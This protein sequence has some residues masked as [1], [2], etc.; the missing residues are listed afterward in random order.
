MKNKKLLLITI[1]LFMISTIVYASLL[2]NL[3]MS[4]E[5]TIRALADIRVTN[6]SYD[7][8]NSSG[9]TLSY[10]STFTKNTIISG[11]TLPNTSSNMS[12]IVTITNNGEM[13]QAIYNLTNES[14]NNGLYATITYT[15]ENN[16]TYTNVPINEALP[17][18][19]PLKSR[20]TIIVTYQTTTPGTINVVSTFD[21]RKVYYIDYVTRSTSTIERTIK[22]HNINTTITDQIPIKQGYPFA[23]WTDEQSGEVVKFNPGDLYTLNEDKTLYALYTKDAYV[24]TFDVDNGEENQT[25]EIKVGD[26]VGTLPTVTKD[27]YHFEGWFTSK[28]GG[29]QITISTVPT[30]DTTYYAHY[31]AYTMTIN[32]YAGGASKDGN[33]TLSNQKLTTD[34]YNYDGTDLSSNGLKN[35]DSASGTW[36]LVKEGY[37]ADKYWH[38]N[39]ATSNTKVH[40]DTKYNKIQDLAESIGKLNQFKTSNIEINIYA[41]WIANE[42]NIIFDKNSTYAT[43]IMS[44]QPMIYGQTDTLN[45]NLFEKEGCTFVGWNTKADGSGTAY[46][47][48]ES[49]SNLVTSGNITLYAQWINGNYT[50]TFD[51]NGGTGT[52]LNQTIEMSELTA[53]KSNEFTNTGYT[54]VGWN[55]KKDGSGISYLDEQEVLN[56]TSINETITLYAQWTANG[57]ALIGNTIYNSLQTA[58]DAVSTTSETPTTIILLK[59][60]SEYVEIESGQNIIFNFQNFILSNDGTKNILYNQGNITITN[61][62]LRSNTSQGAINNYGKL[63]MTGGKIETTNASTR[64]AIYNA[65][66]DVEIS[67]T[68]YLSSMSNSRATLQ[69]VRYNNKEG[70]ITIKSGTIISTNYSAIQLDAG[71]LIIGTDDSELSIDSPH[72]KG[73]NNGILSNTKEYYFYDG[74][75]EG[76]NSF[77]N[78]TKVKTNDNYSME[79]VQYTEGSVTYKKTYLTK[80]AVITLDPNEGTIDTPQILVKVGEMIGELPKPTRENYT[81]DGWYNEDEEEITELFIVEGDMILYAHWIRSEDYYVASIG[82]IQYHSIQAAINAVPANT[83]TTIKLIRNTKEVVNIPSNKNII[84]DGQNY[85]LSNL[86]NSAII[87]NNGKLKIINGTIISTSINAAVI[88]NLGELSITGGRISATGLRQAIYNDGGQLEI[89]GTAYLSSTTSERATIQNRKNETSNI[90]GTTLITGGTIVSTNFAAVFNDE[91]L[92]TIGIEDGNVDITTPILQGAT[93]AVSINSEKTTEFNL[94]D[95]ILK[96]IDD[97]ISGTVNDKEDNY[98]FVTDITVVIDNV[99]YNVTYLVLEE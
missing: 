95:G 30:K 37:H 49:V 54:F 53:L 82:E 33:I 83:E 27:G 52:M 93:N 34:T 26:S 66:G 99:Q 25:K 19:V 15:D 94:Y 87:T 78:Q 38:L 77:S 7:S 23:G 74:S 55:T 32:Y 13:D 40:E 9:G 59:N 44:N 48:E 86:N 76:K 12:Y 97:P 85:V 45:S 92:L 10:E 8:S 17:I 73:F 58:V 72:I 79:T 96:G 42:Y 2:T 47:D 20:K 21:F 18:I 46:L 62:T 61:G 43:G 14:N 63:V 80:K 39:N 84:L 88:N 60:I 50:V 6:I 68:V 70:T 81:F 75:I 28:T 57:V 5:T 98:E 1:I 22:Y 16:I 36:N 56:L 51:G 31:T 4:T 91:G 90:A 11:F 35:Y 24:I 64:Q 71:S 3:T 67:G 41:G 69:N 89:S 29:T 65:G